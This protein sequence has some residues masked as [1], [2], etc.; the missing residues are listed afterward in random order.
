MTAA[1]AGDEDEWAASGVARNT[2]VGSV[3]VRAGHLVVVAV[4][5]R[6]QSRQF[7]I[8]ARS[9]GN[10]LEA[11]IIKTR[12]LSSGWWGARKGKA[13]EPP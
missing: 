8:R 3:S 4:G 2:D 1:R 10:D 13:G 12:R 11:E 6:S 5:V 9:V 7:V